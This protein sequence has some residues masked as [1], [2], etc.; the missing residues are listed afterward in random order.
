MFSTFVKGGVFF[1]MELFDKG[2]E[3]SEHYWFES[4]F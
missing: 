2:N 4:S 3:H 1:M